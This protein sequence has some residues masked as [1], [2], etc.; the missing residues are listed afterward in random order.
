MINVLYLDDEEHNLT[1]F[2][3]AFRRDFTVFV[4]TE[5]SE[6]LSILKDHPIEVVISDQKMPTISGVEFFELIMPDYPNP[7]RMLLTGHADI[8]AVIDAINKGRIYKYI[9]KPWNEAELRKLVEEA[10]YLYKTRI[11]S[12][13]QATDYSIKLYSSQEK[14]A[15]LSKDLAS[16]DELSEES[17]KAYSN[18]I[19]ELIKMLELPKML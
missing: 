12:E 13:S 11:E 2:R 15:V 1:S 10:S 5:P 6:A 4:T 17:R 16:C 8:D 3:A 9:S 14:L 19:N 7:V 18:R